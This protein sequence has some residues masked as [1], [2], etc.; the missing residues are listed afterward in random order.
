[1]R[2]GVAAIWVKNS[3]GERSLMCTATPEVADRWWTIWVHA[4]HWCEVTAE[5]HFDQLGDVPMLTQGD[6]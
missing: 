2:T 1:M 6:R 5:N 3:K 4:G